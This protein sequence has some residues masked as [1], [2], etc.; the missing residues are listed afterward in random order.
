MPPRGVN[1]A[2]QVPYA[3]CCPPTQAGGQWA[4][5]LR[6]C[7]RPL[8]HCC[9]QSAPRRVP[10]SVLVF[11][12]SAHSAVVVDILYSARAPGGALTEPSRTP[13]GSGDST[14]AVGCAMAACT[15]VASAE[16][17]LLS[18]GGAALARAAEALR[19]AAGAARGRGDAPAERRALSR[20]CTA[21]L[22]RG[23]AAGAR[24]E[25]REAAARGVWADWR[26]RPP[27]YVAALRPAGP[28]PGRL[29]RAGRVYGRAC[30]PEVGVQNG[31]DLNPRRAHKHT[32]RTSKLLLA[33]YLHQLSG[34]ASMASGSIALYCVPPARRRMRSPPAARSRYPTASPSWTSSGAAMSVN[35]REMLRQDKR[36]I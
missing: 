16:R 29:A 3:D 11:R 20:L 14:C 21:L 12:R 4:G 31:G 34:S 27:E 13:G 30:W 5:R 26:Q 2:A 32:A 1:I 6:A 36:A 22:W 35:K 7:H 17:L 23:D 18:G 15:A 9:P 25:A 28:F 19:A 10:Q 33:Q 8:C 24:R